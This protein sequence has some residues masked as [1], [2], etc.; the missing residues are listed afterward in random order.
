MQDYDQ[1][2][3]DQNGLL[4]CATRSRTHTSRTDTKTVNLQFECNANISLATMHG[5][6]E[7][8]S[9]A[10]DFISVI[11]QTQK[12]QFLSYSTHQRL[13]LLAAKLQLRYLT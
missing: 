4:A 1:F 12:N 2:R 10:I 8:D 6:N 5:V 13:L 11:E 3:E 7:F 9:G